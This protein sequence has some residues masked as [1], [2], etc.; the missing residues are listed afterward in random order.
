[1]AIAAVEAVRQSSA[2]SALI[3]VQ[4]V[5]GLTVSACL[6]IAAVEAVRQSGAGS[7]LIAVQEVI[8]LAGSAYV[9]GSASFTLCFASKTDFSI[10]EEAIFA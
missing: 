5:S 6:A 8:G 1:M 3:A 7:A 10:A 9:R 2:G 4:E